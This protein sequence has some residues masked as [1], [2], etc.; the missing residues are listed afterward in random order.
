MRIQRPAWWTICL[1]WASVSIPGIG[2]SQ[3]NPPQKTPAQDAGSGLQFLGTYSAPSVVV[4]T[5]TGHAS[6][7]PPK[8]P[9]RR[10]LDEIV[11]DATILPPWPVDLAWNSQST[12]KA[13]KGVG[14]AP[15]ERG[16]KALR[17]SRFS[18]ARFIYRLGS[19]RHP[20]C[21][22]LKWNLALAETY[23]SGDHAFSQLKPFLQAAP[24]PGVGKLIT[25][26]LDLEGHDLAAA[27]KALGG[28][29]CAESDLKTRS[30]APGDIRGRDDLWSCAML[31]QA[32]ERFSAARRDLMRIISAGES[33]PEVWFALGSVELKQAR[34]A[35]R[36]LAQ[37][38]PKSVWARK[39]ESQAVAARYPLLAQRLYSSTPRESSSSGAPV[40][41]SVEPVK[42]AIQ[43]DAKLHQLE[44]LPP[45][46]ASLYQESVEALRL[47]ELAFEQ[48][49][50]SNRF[51]EQ[52][53]A[54]EALA[55][56]E[57]D[58]T[59]AAISE[60]RGCLKLYP[61]SAILHAGLGQLLLH[62][63]RLPQ[64]REELA[65][66]WQLDPRDPLVAFN[67][68]DADERLNQPKLA[69]PLLDQALRLDPSLL[70][71]RWSRGKAYMELGEYHQAVSDLRAAEA[72]DPTGDLMWQLSRAYL[73][74]GDAQAAREAVERSEE[75][76]K[77]AQASDK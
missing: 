31:E 45:A 34:S 56:T 53:C 14:S 8:L 37:V 42:T 39:L 40:I 22:P 48:A 47:S 65:E 24:S 2:R 25:G 71:A 51:E 55:A 36:R 59:M 19:Q 5:E 57:E 69:L 9:T 73:K 68:G 30:D 46:P 6:A 15:I 27:G 3:S 11:R 72:T 26:I 43:T 12:G 10:R 17:E 66:A 74:L 61:Q 21:P 62:Q 49:S 67:L 60:Y 35:S 32:R 52:M 16:E 58:D 13:C 77:K 28:E 38:A 1:L 7:Q 64:A 54:L 44:G 70:A 75:Q 4:T 76:R 23:A 50:R 29:E 20:H 18:D 33:A 63:L 41:P